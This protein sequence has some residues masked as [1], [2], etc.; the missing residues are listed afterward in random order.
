[1][2]SLCSWVLA[3][4]SP[5]STPTEFPLCDFGR[6]VFGGESRSSKSITSAFLSR[7]ARR[8]FLDV[9]LALQIPVTTPS[10]SSQLVFSSAGMGIPSI[11]GLG[12]RRV[13]IFVVSRLGRTLPVDW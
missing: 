4:T 2:R 5:P 3:S 7:F 12:S 13:G 10:S 6:G 9:F 1:M 11:V 8:V